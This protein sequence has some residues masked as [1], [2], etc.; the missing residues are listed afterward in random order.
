M[1]AELSGAKRSH[2]V[3]A[4]RYPYGYPGRTRPWVGSI[5]HTEADV[6]R[7]IVVAMSV[8]VLVGAMMGP[9]F[10]H[11]KNIPST[12]KLSVSDKTPKKGTFVTFKIKVSSNNEKCFK[13][14]LVKLIRNSKVVAKKTTN[15]KG[16][17][18]FSVKI[19]AKKTYWGVAKKKAL[20]LAHPHHHVCVKELSAKTKVK[21]H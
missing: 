1:L 17:A 3:F 21:P 19:K 8:A 4:C 15:Y 13:Q 14:R 6:K 2:C 12:V 11:T 10:S 5:E 20:N 18:K 9:A 16:V 7:A